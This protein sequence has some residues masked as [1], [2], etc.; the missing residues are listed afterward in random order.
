MT[1]VLPATSKPP[2][3]NEGIYRVRFVKGKKRR[4]LVSR[5]VDVKVMRKGV[6]VA[7]E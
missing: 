4:E 6:V 3:I 7:V 1:Y 5:V 2:K